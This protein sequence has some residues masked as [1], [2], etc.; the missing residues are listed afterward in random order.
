M[1]ELYT[2]LPMNDQ[3]TRQLLAVPPQSINNPDYGV[4]VGR[5]SFTFPAG[6]WVTIAQRVKLNDPGLFNGEI[7]VWFNGDKVI[8]VKSVSMRDSL[9]SVIQGIHFSTFFGGSSPDWATPTDQRAWFADISGA[10]ITGKA[11]CCCVCSD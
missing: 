8:D 10:V 4:S 3:N 1:G 7:T 2:Y 11:M 5:G 6:Q 9:D